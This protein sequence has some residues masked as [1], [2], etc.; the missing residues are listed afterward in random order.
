MVLIIFPKFRLKTPCGLGD[1]SIGSLRLFLGF[2]GCADSHLVDHPRGSRGPSARC[3]TAR[4]F[5]VFVRVLERLSFDTFFGGFL[6]HE[7]C[8]RSVVECRTVRDEAD[9]PRVHHRQSDFLGALLEVRV[10][11]F[12]RSMPSSQIVR[13]L[14]VDSP[15]RH[16]GRSAWCF[17]DCL[18]PLLF[19]L[20]FRIRLVWDLFLGSVSLL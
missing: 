17:P 9:G 7:V 13:A 12:R 5:F 1:P 6:V 18:S 2:L 16:C 11:I 14:L 10:A 15:S 20:C 8:G 19:E 4:L 3:L